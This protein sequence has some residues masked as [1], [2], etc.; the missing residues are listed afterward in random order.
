[1][2]QILIAFDQLVNTIVW[3]KGDGFGMA[4]ETLSAR[5]WRL[6]RQSKAW[7]VIDAIMFFDPYHCQMSYASEVDRKQL[8][9]EYNEAR[10][11]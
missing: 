6:R 9:R 7:M 5:A 8:P 10:Q 4:D 2:K 3:I 11:P 1:M